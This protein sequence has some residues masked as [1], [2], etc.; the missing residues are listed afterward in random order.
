MEKEKSMARTLADE[1]FYKKQTAFET[2]S[3]AD[4]KASADF[5]KDYADYLFNSKTEREAVRTTAKLLS[6][7]GYKEYTL[8][9]DVSVGGKYYLNNRDKSIIAFRIGTAPIE[10][11]VRI[12]AAHID[13]PR[14]DLKQCPLFEEGSFGY[15]KT[16]YY[17]GIRKYQ[18]PTLPLALHGVVVRRGGEKIEVNIGEDEGDPVFVITDLLPHL[19]REQ[20]KSALNQS[21]GG[22]VLNI[23]VGVAPLME[24]GK[25]ADVDNAVK[26]NIMKLLNE[27]YGIVEADFLSA[28]LCAVPAGRPVDVGFDRCLMGGYG[29]DDKVCAYPALRALIDAP[30]DENTLIC[31]LADKEETGSDGVSGMQCSLL[32]ELIDCISASLGANG[33]VC[34]NNSMCLSADVSAGWDPNYPDV[35]E[36]RNSAIINCGVVMNKYTGGGGKSSTNDAGA[37]FVGKIRDMF[38]RDGV[39]WQ[40]A[41]L[42]KVD[43]GGGGTVAKYIANRNIETVDLGVPV[44]SMHAPFELISKH[45]LYSAY[46]AFVSFC[47]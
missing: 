34:R 45:D 31:V 43:A 8:G 26:L 20:G 23:L 15:L 13:S 11:G 12:S 9:D 42:G 10:N 24:D 7:N 6:E 36:K 46:K 29:H 19:G 37:E 30:G 38:C 44:L 39:L 17:G 28:E 21:F 2:M 41:E 32:P 25:P 14:L 47:K 3:E 16:H 40:T 35:F 33:T 5:A 4:L 18:W 1:L 27:K 22:E